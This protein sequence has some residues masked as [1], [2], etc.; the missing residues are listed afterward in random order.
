LD[1][2]KCKYEDD[3]NKSEDDD[4]QLDIV[5]NRTIN[6]SSINSTAFTPKYKE[7]YTKNEDSVENRCFPSSINTVIPLTEI[8]F[9]ASL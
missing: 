1:S 6:S 4:R 3:I 9:N 2:D 7:E 5:R 8:I